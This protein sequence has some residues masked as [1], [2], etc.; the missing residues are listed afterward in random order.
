VEVLA[1][2]VAVPVREADGNDRESEE[3]DA[4][5]DTI[6]EVRATDSDEGAEALAEAVV[7]EPLPATRRIAWLLMSATYTLPAA[8]TATPVGL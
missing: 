4:D 6:C 5:A 8:S 2:V 1:V 7:T 3:S